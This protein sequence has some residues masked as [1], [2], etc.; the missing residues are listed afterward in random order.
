MCANCFSRLIKNANNENRE[1]T[2]P[3]CRCTISE[4]LCARNLAVEKTVSEL[5]EKCSLCQAIYPRS[6]L[7]AHQNEECTKRH[8]GCDHPG[9]TWD[10]Q[11]GEMEAHIA[12]HNVA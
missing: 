9:C 11:Y 2:C 6:R 12:R 10:G 3:G 1:A 5:P 7:L 4:S 8:I